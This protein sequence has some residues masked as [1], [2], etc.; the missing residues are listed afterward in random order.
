MKAMARRSPPRTS[1]VCRGWARM[2]DMSW[3]MNRFCSGIFI[4]AR[5]RR[6]CRSPMPRRTWPRPRGSFAKLFP[7][8]VLGWM[9]PLCFTIPA[10]G[11]RRCANSSRPIKM[12][13]ASGWHSCAWS[14]RAFKCANGCRD[15]LPRKNFCDP[16]AWPLVNSSPVTLPILRIVSG[17]TRRRNDMSLGNPRGGALRRRRCFKRG[18]R[19][20]RGFCPRA[21]LIR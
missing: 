21:R 10:S 4:G 3:P 5:A 8:P 9:I 1:R 7:R 12:N 17:W 2:S 19:A 14:V 11:N 6:R 13:L 18:C 20:R 16:W 15:I